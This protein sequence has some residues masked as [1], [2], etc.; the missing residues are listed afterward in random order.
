MKHYLL[1][2]GL[3][4]S[5]VFSQSIADFLRTPLNL[6]FT[7]TNGYDSNV[8]RLSPGE[9]ERAALES[10]LLGKMSTFDSHYLRAELLTEAVVHLTRRK[11]I[12]TS[13]S[14]SFTRYS[15]SPDKRYF[16][17][18]LSL[19]YRWDSYRW[20]RYSI[21]ELNNFY[22]R[23]YINQDLSDEQLLGC[24]FTDRDQKM[25]FSHPVASRIWI[26]SSAGFLQRYYN[27]GFTEFDLDISYLRGKVS[28]RFPEA[29]TIGAEA[30]VGQADNITF[31][32]TARSSDLDRSYS[33]VQYYLPVKIT[34]TWAGIDELG[35]AI[36]DEFRVYS[37]EDV[38]DPLHSG[39]AHRDSK[40]DVWVKKQI[41]NSLWVKGQVRYRMRKTESEY[42][43]VENL[44]SFNQIQAWIQ[45]GW[46]MVYD[47]Y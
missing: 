35:F 21:R 22:L 14:L 1:G 9:Q 6:D 12:T 19:Q 38:L 43:W 27:A 32:K 18:K 13:G 46:G 25:T 4:L 44:K 3:F 23:D 15:P 24:F 7:V 31:G 11:R 2:C 34:K 33:Y 41:G 8:L 42:K 5:N 45:I 17:G 20:V 47:R 29:G 26:T 39:R 10:G 37:V 36:R 40:L 28:I 16:G 30:E